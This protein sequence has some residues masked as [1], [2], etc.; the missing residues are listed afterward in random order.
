MT[1]QQIIAITLGGGLLGWQFWPAISSLFSKFRLPSI[2]VAKPA[3][4]DLDLSDL[5]A[6]KQVHARFKRLKC[7]EGESACLVCF[8]H[9]FREHTA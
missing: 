9:F 6:L 1:T 8:E 2:S 3:A 5:A 4:I 7:K